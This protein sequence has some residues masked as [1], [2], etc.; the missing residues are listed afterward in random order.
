MKTFRI[1]KSLFLSIV[2]LFSLAA[3]THYAARATQ[4]P[5]AMEQRR[6]YS[7]RHLIAA[8][9]IA[10]V[11]SVTV[12]ELL[13]RV[14]P[15]FLSPATARNA[16]GEILSPVVYINGSFA[17]DVSVL[18]TVWTDVISEIRYVS[19]RDA[20]TYHGDSHSGGEIMIYTYQTRPARPRT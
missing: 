14:R 3:C 2:S 10:R 20:T 1:D 16:A 7:T 6:V 8:P 4:I 9:E 17:G 5:T 19:P 13:T 11:P 18:R 15:E 12:Y